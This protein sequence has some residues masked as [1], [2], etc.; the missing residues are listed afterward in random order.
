MGSI[1]GPTRCQKF[2]T[3]PD[4][5]AKFFPANVFPQFVDGIALSEVRDWPTFRVARDSLFFSPAI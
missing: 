1:I 5:G 3:R 2:E 4:W